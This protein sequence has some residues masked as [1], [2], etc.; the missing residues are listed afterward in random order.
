MTYGELKDRVL[1]LIFSYSIA[2]DEI[3]LSYNN[4]E[5]YVKQIPGLL[6]TCQT[7]IYQIKKIEDSLLLKDLVRE[8]LGSVYMYHFP[9]DCL[10]MKPG[11]IVPRHGEHGPVF[12]R[13]NRYKLFGGTKFMAPK[14]L[15]DDAIFEYEKRAVPLPANIKDNYVLRNPDEVNEIMPFYIAAFVVMYDD[16]FRYSALYNEFE[17]RLQR[18]MA[19]PTYTEVSEVTDVYGGFDA[20]GW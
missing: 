3:E 16:A 20:W 18:M 2:G 5:D 4:Q 17:T 6:S 10:K 19:N 15:P 1:Q 13:D 9:D 8:D 12:V 14:D 11:I 7:Y